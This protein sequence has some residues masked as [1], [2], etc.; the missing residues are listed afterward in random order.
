[1]QKQALF[2]PFVS[3]A[4]NRVL[5]EACEIETKD[6]SAFALAG[7]LP[8]GILVHRRLPPLKISSSLPDSSSVPFIPLGGERQRESKVR[9][10]PR[11]Q[12]SAPSLA[13][14]PVCL[15]RSPTFH[16]LGHRA[17]NRS[18]VVVLEKKEKLCF[19]IVGSRLYIRIVFYLLRCQ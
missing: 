14:N 10:C 4:A 12:H 7:Y 8:D 19:V 5:F 11:T 13:T 18:A 1:M 2:P 6:G 16:S 9:P 15:I 3:P 17:R